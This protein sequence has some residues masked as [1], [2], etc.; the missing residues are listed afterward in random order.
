MGFI[1]VSVME[2]G[3][4]DNS[5]TAITTLLIMFTI[6]LLPSFPC[7]NQTTLQNQLKPFSKPEHF[8]SKTLNS[9]SLPTLNLG[10]WIL[11]CP[12]HFPNHV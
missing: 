1:C 3:A 8:T 2:S 6:G 11:N 12:N 10:S 9:Q 4:L 5:Q 7:P